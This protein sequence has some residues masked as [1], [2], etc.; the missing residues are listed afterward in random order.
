M[1]AI[2]FECNT[3]LAVYHCTARNFFTGTRDLDGPRYSN[4][5]LDHEELPSSYFPWFQ[6]PQSRRGFNRSYNVDDSFLNDKETVFDIRGQR[7]FRS[8]CHFGNNLSN[9]FITSTNGL[10]TGLYAKSDA[11]DENLATR[12]VNARINLNEAE[13]SFRRHPRTENVKSNTEQL[14]CSFKPNLTK[15]IKTNQDDI[16]TTVSAAADRALRSKTRLIDLEQ[17]MEEI[18]EKQARREKRTEALRA[19]VNKTKVTEN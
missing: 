2:I 8:P 16:N 4:F 10:K 17:E 7:T 5:D 19:L 18:I 1:F 13:D 12:N 15:W 14:L 6:W 9:E 3:A 11:I